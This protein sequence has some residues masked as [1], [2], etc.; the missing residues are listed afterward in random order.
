MTMHFKLSTIT[1]SVLIV[2]CCGYRH[3]TAAHLADIE[4]YINDRPDSALAELRGIDTT[5]LRSRRDK[6]KYSL[7]HAMALDKCYIDVT[8]DSIIASAA[9]YYRHHGSADDKM[10]AL[11][12][13]GVVYKNSKEYNKA[14]ILFT[15][16]ENWAGKAIDTHAKSILFLTFSELYRKVYNLHKQQ[17]YV[18]KA[19][20][21]LSETN[22]PMYEQA[23]GQLAVPFMMHREW[24]IADSLFR[25]AMDHSK[26]HPQIMR[27]IISNYGRM[28]M[29]Q[30]NPDAEGAISLFN[31]KIKEYGGALTPE[32]AGAYAY[33]Y[34][35]LG[36][37]DIA[38]AMVQRFESF[39][40]KD[41]IVVLPWMYRIFAFRKDYE[42]A[43]RYLS[44]AQITEESTINNTL[45][46][47]ITQTLNDYQALSLERERNRKRIIS[48]FSA[49][50]LLIAALFVL[51][52]TLRKRNIQHEMDALL[53]IH[54]SLKME[55][56]ALLISS[57]KKNDS[58][59]NKKK[60]K[61]YQ[62]Q[63]QL[64]KE[65]IDS[66]RKR[67]VFDYMLWMNEN[68]LLS[69]ANTLK[70]LKT[71][72]MSFY[73]IER[74]QKELEKELDTSLDG[75]VSELKKDL[76][77]NVQKD[78][79]FLCL[80]LLDTKPIVVAEIL[81]MNENAVYIKRSRLKKSIASLG[82]KYSYLLS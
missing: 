13:E 18:E 1:L 25:R 74:N 29:I 77:I 26:G 68:R 30:D 54:E 5:I 31:L 44:E 38:D 24:Y 8:S 79:H 27:Y 64:R 7:L 19:L 72:I 71:E 69:D 61:I 62:V 65:R 35:R 51:I 56:Q 45:E 16:A 20:S 2:A 48:L 15:Q 81:G 43:Y 70:E 73:K 6:A 60:E 67:K 50:L 78:I 21:V 4:S 80:W 3:D 40:G 46:D 53:S 11:F 58:S 82:G 52:A 57:E 59:R 66:F 39:K 32:E 23:L 36:N 10:K 75:L 17:E 22:D 55:H 41:R 9:R 14:A 37:D 34:A 47:S 28:K 63:T 76:S 49:L 42:S 12:Y 33:A